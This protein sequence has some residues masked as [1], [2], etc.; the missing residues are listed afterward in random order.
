MIPG[1]D[2]RSR[3][4][5]AR[6]LTCRITVADWSGKR[7][8]PGFFIEA[9]INVTTTTGTNGQ[10]FISAGNDSNMGGVAVLNDEGGGQTRISLRSDSWSI[11]NGVTTVVPDGFHSVRVT[12]EPAGD[13]LLTVDGGLVGSASPYNTGFGSSELRFGDANGGGEA[14]WDYVVVNTNIPEPASMTLLALGGLAMLRRRR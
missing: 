8:L 14:V 10:V 12:Q 9:G 4:P 3:R 6:D 1:P 13:V 2:I 5:L 11:V 7:S